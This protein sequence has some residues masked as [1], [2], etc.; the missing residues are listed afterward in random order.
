MGIAGM[1]ANVGHC[2]F[3]LAATA[4]VCTVGLFKT[5]VAAP[6][7]AQLAPLTYFAYTCIASRQASSVVAA[8][9]G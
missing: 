4:R 6:M 7:D 1:H 5:H 8:G 9:S 2:A 3:F